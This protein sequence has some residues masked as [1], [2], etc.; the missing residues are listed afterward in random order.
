[1][2]LLPRVDTFEHT[3]KYF[4]TPITIWKSRN[5]STEHVLWPTY[6][7]QYVYLFLEYSN[8]AL[9]LNTGDNFHSGSNFSLFLK[10]IAIAAQMIIG[11][12]C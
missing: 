4:G 7:M 10:I 12:F 11:Y 8:D 5:S 1:M 9:L 6:H 2:F 3:Y